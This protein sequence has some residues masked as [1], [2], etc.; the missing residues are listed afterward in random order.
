MGKSSPS[1]PP[2]PDPAA[3]AAAQGAANKEAVKASAQYNQINQVTP[4]GDLTYTG[5][6]GSP[7]RTLTQTLT[8]ED[9]ARL[10]QQRALAGQ[11]TQFAGTLVPQVTSA[12][13][14]PLDFSGLPSIPT[15][16]NA[17]RDSAANAAYGRLTNLLSPQITEGRK[18][19]ETSLI[20]RGLPIGSEAYGKATDR[21][22][23]QANDALL[24]AA[25]QSVLTGD[26]E[27]A[28][29]FAQALS[30][31]QQGIN[32]MLT[33]RSQP[34]NEISALIQGSPAIGLPNFQN[35]SSYAVQPADVLGSN[36]LSAQQNWNNYNSQ[37]QS[38]NA[39]QQGTM[40]LLGTAAMA[41]AVFF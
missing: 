36:A 9:Q 26:Q 11:L 40:G 35:T 2:A 12:L 8:P 20:N 21:F 18:Q 33:S 5:D 28:Q 14:Q 31:R 29:Q 17:A 37:L 32:E 15:D 25:N 1:P 34:I 38:Q 16:F 3:T 27:A 39:Q 22:E 24:Q 13:G 23:R 30:G 4:F 10:D 6:L 7:E 41:A 19:Q